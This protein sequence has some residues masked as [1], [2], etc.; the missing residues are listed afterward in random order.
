MSARFMVGRHRQVIP[1]S[2][3]RYANTKGASLAKSGIYKNTSV[4]FLIIIS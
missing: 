1:A 4:R 2:V 3:S